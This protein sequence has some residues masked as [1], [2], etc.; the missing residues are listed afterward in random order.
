VALS[1]GAVGALAVVFT[2]GLGA[3]ATADAGALVAGMASVIGSA[4]NDGR[5]NLAIG[6][7]DFSVLTLSDARGAI[8]NSLLTGL[9]LAHNATFSNGYAGHYSGT[10]VSFFDSIY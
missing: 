6:P 8:K 1:Q 2:S 3:I 7:T 10:E 9:D 5:A 4:T